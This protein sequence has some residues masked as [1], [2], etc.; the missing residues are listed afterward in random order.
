MDKRHKLVFIISSGEEVTIGFLSQ[1]RNGFVLGTSEVEGTN[2][3]HLTI[4][5]KKG[6]ISSHITPQKHPSDKQYFPPMSKKEFGEVIQKT[7][8]ENL[9]SPLTDEHLLQQ[10]LYNTQKLVDW[11]ESMKNILYEKRVTTREVIHIINFKGIMEKTP[12]LIEELS[13]SPSSYFGLCQAKEILEDTSKIWG[14]TETKSVVIPLRIN[15]IF[16]ILQY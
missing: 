3:S 6:K 16:W 2:T 12:K 4:L 10:V 11:L 13:K 15:F 1:S 7:V 14:F 8:N 9:I 5:S